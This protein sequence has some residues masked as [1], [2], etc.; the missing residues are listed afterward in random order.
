MNY[1][2]RSAGMYLGG[3]TVKLGGFTVKFPLWTRQV[4][5]EI[6]NRG[7]TV[8]FMKGLRGF[9][10]FL[11]MFFDCNSRQRRGRWWARWS[12]VGMAGC[13]SFTTRIPNFDFSTRIFTK[14]IQN[15][16]LIRKSVSRSVY[17]VGNIL[18]WYYIRIKKARARGGNVTLELWCTVKPIS[19]LNSHEIKVTLTA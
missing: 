10:V 6:E 3:F 9:T 18:L 19:W 2:A 16:N 5:V 14:S 8:K 7:F 13:G 12:L 15:A 11:R 17:K 1:C 4:Q